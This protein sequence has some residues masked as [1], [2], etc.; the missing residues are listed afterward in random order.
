MV[1]TSYVDEDD[2]LGCYEPRL[3]VDNSMDVKTGPC[4]GNWEGGMLTS[5]L[6]DET[7]HCVETLAVD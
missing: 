5:E 7:L 3:Y 6:G 2:T 1:A 4:G